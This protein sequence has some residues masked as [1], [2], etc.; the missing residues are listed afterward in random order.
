MDFQGWR[1]SSAHNTFLLIQVTSGE[2]SP[3]TTQAVQ[4]LRLVPQGRQPLG[5]SVKVQGVIH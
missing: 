3:S 1:H 2:R 5:F 4:F